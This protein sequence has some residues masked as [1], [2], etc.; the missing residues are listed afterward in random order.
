M[1]EDDKAAKEVLRQLRLEGEAEAKFHLRL[2]R[3]YAREERK[4]D[5]AELKHKR[6]ADRAKKKAEKLE[7][8]SRRKAA[9]AAN[10]TLRWRHPRRK[11]WKPPEGYRK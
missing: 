7:A 6:A 9:L 5:L 11:D 8:E 10:P 4:A 1:A 2:A 3:Q